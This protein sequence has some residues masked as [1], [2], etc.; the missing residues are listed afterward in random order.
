[1]KIIN[2]K[3]TL[4]LAL[5]DVAKAFGYKLEVDEYT[6]VYHNGYSK[7]DI[8]SQNLNLPSKYENLDKIFPEAIA[9][10]LENAERSA[11]A[12]YIR[13]ERI[14]A[15]ESCLSKIDLTG[16]GAEYISSENES[17]SA[18]AGITSV[19]IDERNDRV[20]VDILNPEHLINAVINGK[21]YFYPDLS[22]TEP[23]STDEIKKR[24]HYL[25]DYFDV[26]GESKPS[27]YINSNYSPDVD[28]AYF[29]EDIQFRLDEMAL[30]NVKSAVKDSIESG[31]DVQEALKLASK[32]SEYSS[33]EIVSSI[34][35]ESKTDLSQWQ[36]L[37]NSL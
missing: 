37:L 11:W 23:A 3:I 28:E 36:N 31:L 6:D 12:S 34:V 19:T 35:E 27:E 29:S 22:A 8:R 7:K 24:F 13:K 16:G 30:E 9:I 26:F 25:N 14:K 15:L 17:V 33:K 2:R 4:E 20:V 10:S 1:M 32:F 5:D 21:G 18:K